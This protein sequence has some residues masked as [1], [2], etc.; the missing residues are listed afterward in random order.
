MERLHAP[1]HRVARGDQVH[2]D[3]VEVGLHTLGV[4]T[5]WYVRDGGLWMEYRGIFSFRQGGVG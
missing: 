4:R 1:R 2:T 5:P 3:R